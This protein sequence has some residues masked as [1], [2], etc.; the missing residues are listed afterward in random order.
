MKGGPY[1]GFAPSTRILNVPAVE[2]AFPPQPPVGGGNGLWEVTQACRAHMPHNRWTMRQV[3]HYFNI[4]PSM[5]ESGEPLFTAYLAKKIDQAGMFLCLF[6]PSALRFLIF[7]FS[8]SSRRGQP[9][10]CRDKQLAVA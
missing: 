6:S 2:L 9:Q 7:V 1:D 10:C 4:T 5:H 8:R 3:L